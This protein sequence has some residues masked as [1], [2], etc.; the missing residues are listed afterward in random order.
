MERERGERYGAGVPSSAV[1][2]SRSRPMSI[3]TRRTLLSAGVALAGASRLA[4]SSRSEPR[5]PQKIGRTKHTK[6][7]LNAE[8]WFPDLSF[9]DRVRKG[10]DFGY[11]AIEFWPWRRKDVDM[12]ALGK[13][14]AELKLDIAQF[15]A[16]GFTPGMNDPKNHDAVERE[17]A[18]SCKVANDLGCKAMTVVG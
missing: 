16:W 10:A 3:L 6:F 8:I 17:I 7:A 2:V 13:L 14:C 12:G 1:P 18:E 11:P 15:T 4:A 9:L 5:L